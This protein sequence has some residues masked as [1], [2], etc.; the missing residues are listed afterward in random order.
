VTVGPPLEPKL[1][2]GLL[3]DK[4]IARSNERTTLRVIQTAHDW[5]E[6]ASAD[7]LEEDLG[8][9]CV[10]N[11]EPGACWTLH[12]VCGDVEYRV[13]SGVGGHWVVGM[14]V[15]VFE[16]LGAQFSTMPVLYSLLLLL[17]VEK[18]VGEIECRGVDRRTERVRRDSVQ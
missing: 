16:V 14:C 10:A 17:P 7:G 11:V 13:G 6:D 2:V 4:D 1:I 5:L 8:I 9:T 12:I 3:P 18:S 15:R